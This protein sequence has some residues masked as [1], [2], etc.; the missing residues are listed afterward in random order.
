MVIWVKCR[1]F[2][3][4]PCRGENYQDTLVGLH[5]L[6]PRHDR[7]TA[8]YVIVSEHCLHIIHLLQSWN[9]LLMSQR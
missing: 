6:K 3:A 9:R 1:N 7:S 4:I 2:H 8:N 5:G